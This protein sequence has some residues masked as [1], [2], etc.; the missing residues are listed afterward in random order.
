[1]SDRLIFM[2]TRNDAT[3][4][5]ADALVDAA[6]ALGIR[7]IG[8]KDVGLD[9]TGL[10]AL[11]AR[12]KAAGAE[13]VLEM[14]SLDPAAEAAAARLAVD[15]G[16][17]LLL[18]GRHPDAVLPVIAGHGLRYMPF[19]GAV[20]G[21]PSMLSGSDDEIVADAAR[22]AA[23]DG[24]SGVDLLAWRRPG[25]AAEL[26]A[27]VVA[28]I[29]PKPVIVAG[30]IDSPAAVAAVVAAGA[31]GF[32]IGTAAIEGSFAGAAPELSAQLG[33]ALKA[34]AEAE[35]RISTAG[36]VDLARAFAGF[37]DCWSPRIGGRINDMHLKLVKLSGAFVWHR[38][39]VE[40]ELFLVTR[41]RLLM[42]FRDRDEEVA[43]GQFIIVPHGVEH[44]PVALD[45]PCEVVLL[46]PATTV[47]TGTAGGGRTVTHL[48]SI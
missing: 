24:V 19:A 35:G 13:S 8:F 32:T 42:K 12:I 1:M 47:N 45:E 21:H 23:R 15:L 46:E 36:T 30:S 20:S 4:A 29:G 9:R 37:D 41:G 25:D 44:C 22:L 40:D 5:G 38:H 6:A 31:A 48:K 14:V 3:V 16:V 2:A 27:K 34:L 18:G 26:I 43:A 7:R 28:A 11:H 17:D 10:A 33:A 39:E